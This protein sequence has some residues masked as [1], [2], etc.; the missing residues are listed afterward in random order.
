MASISAPVRV[1]DNT[2][3]IRHQTPGTKSEENYRGA[4]NDQSRGV[5]QG[6]IL[7]QK[8]ADG[9]DG[10]MSNKTILLSGEAEINSKPQWRSTLMTSNAFMAQLPES[11]KRRPY[12]ISG[13][14]IPEGEA[15]TILVEGFLA[16]VME[17]F[18]LGELAG[19]SGPN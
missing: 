4:L 13:R 18:G 12:F 8:G 3:V 16:E 1:L 7:V 14:G 2:T 9:T 10:R 6:N 17:E 5:F 11:W 19:F 15:K